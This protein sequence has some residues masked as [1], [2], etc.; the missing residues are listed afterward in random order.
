M[1]SHFDFSSLIHAGFLQP[2]ANTQPMDSE[3]FLRFLSDLRDPQ[4]TRNAH[5]RMQSILAKSAGQYF[6]CLQVIM[7]LQLF[8]NKDADFRVE[9]CVCFFPRTT[10][11]RAYNYVINCA[12]HRQRHI[13]IQRIGKL[14]LFFDG[15][16]TAVGY[17]KLN[18][19]LQDERYICQELLHMA[20]YEAGHHFVDCEYDGVPFQIPQSWVDEELPK[21]GCISFFY[22]STKSSNKKRIAA[23]S[24]D[25]KC[26]RGHAPTTSQLPLNFRLPSIPDNFDHEKVLC[27]WIFME[28]LRLV[29]EALSGFVDSAQEVFASLDKD[30]SQTVDRLEFTD[31]LYKSGIML[32][33]SE[34][35]YARSRLSVQLFLR[36]QLHIHVLNIPNS[37]VHPFMR[38]HKHIQWQGDA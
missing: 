9:V 12:G 24:S 36:I 19:K 10:D 32:N 2:D 16:S 18:L 5:E 34:M 7:L 14:N 31:G 26:L 8:K 15:A 35:R 29:K 27:P 38:M 11:W 6:T 25:G 28:K 20:E 30:A 4:Q 1:P 13:A 37:A 33:S 23:G 3:V 17:W 22:A 21:S